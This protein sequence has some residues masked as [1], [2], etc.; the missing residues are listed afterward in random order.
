MKYLVVI[1]GLFLAA[2]AG[3]TATRATNALGIAC[4]THAEALKQLAP[5]KA[6]MSQDAVDIVDKSVSLVRPV[7]SKKGAVI[8]PKTAIKIVNSGI[9]LLKDVK[10]KL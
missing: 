9:A 8:D 5:R 6:G 1:V 7:C 3:D 2:C 10:S 4:K